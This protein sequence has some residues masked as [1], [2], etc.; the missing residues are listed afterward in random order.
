MKYI[1]RASKYS[2]RHGFY[3]FGIDLNEIDGKEMLFFGG[4]VFLGVDENGVAR[5]RISK[6]DCD[7]VDDATDNS[8][9]KTEANGIYGIVLG[10]VVKPDETQVSFNG[11]ELIT[12]IIENK[13]KKIVVVIFKDGDKRVMKCCEGEEYC[14]NTAVSYAIS[15]HI[16]GSNSAF[17]KFVKSFVPKKM[18]FSLKKHCENFK[19]KEADKD[20]EAIKG[21]TLE[22][23]KEKHN[24]R[25]YEYFKEDCYIIDDSFMVFKNEFVEEDDGDN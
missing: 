9:K 4:D 20:V 19:L 5:I 1:F 3:C 8:F 7:L 21:L 2:R 25:A 10:T 14:L 16:F 24:V 23:I 12:K 22:Q 18:V 13:E 11:K 17:K 15:E 6:E